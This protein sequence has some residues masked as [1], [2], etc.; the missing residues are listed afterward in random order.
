LEF[1]INKF[2]YF[3]LKSLLLFFF[4]ISDIFLLLQI[5]FLNSFSSLFHF[6]VLLLNFLKSSQLFLSLLLLEALSLFKLVQ[7]LLYYALLNLVFNQLGVCKSFIVNM[8]KNSLILKLTDG[9]CFKF[10]IYSLQVLDCLTFLHGFRILQQVLRKAS[11]LQNW[12]DSNNLDDLFALF[13]CLLN[14]AF[15]LL[16]IVLKSKI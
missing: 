13:L 5:E 12:M 16:L 11:R 7:I 3:L 10:W 4:Y 14:E 8:R 6:C 2:F 1:L 15:T 9:L